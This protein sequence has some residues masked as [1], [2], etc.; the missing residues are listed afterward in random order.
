M[1]RLS[2]TRPAAKCTNQQRSKEKREQICNLIG[3][4]VYGRLR[5]IARVCDW[6]KPGR[7]Q[8]VRKEL[9]ALLKFFPRR[10][11]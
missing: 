3:C 9:L 10:K 8:E 7:D 2:R 6:S 11:K 5:Y 1:V 4:D